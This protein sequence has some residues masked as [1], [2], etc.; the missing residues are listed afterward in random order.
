MWPSPRHESQWSPTFDTNS[1]QPPLKPPPPP[2]PS[3]SPLLVLLPICFSAPPPLRSLAP[4]LASSSSLPPPPNLFYLLLCSSRLL[5]FVFKL[6]LFTLSSS[7]FLYAGL[8]KKKKKII[9][10]RITFLPFTSLL[11]PLTP[12]SSLTL[13]S[14]IF[15][16]QISVMFSLPLQI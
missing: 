11:F 15:V 1:W 16:S 6:S 12:P 2:F 13:C 10:P 5:P 4:S 3:I 14:S 9:C 8:K 7:V